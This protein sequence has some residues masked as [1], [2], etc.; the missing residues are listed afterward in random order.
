MS[1]WRLVPDTISLQPCT[2]RAFGR[3]LCP[4]V[5]APGA[6]TFPLGCVPSDPPASRGPCIPSVA[7][8]ALCLL[9]STADISTEAETILSDL[10]SLAETGDQAQSTLQSLRATVRNTGCP[11]VR[12]DAHRPIAP[13]KREEPER[14]VHMTAQSELD[15]QCSRKHSG[16]APLSAGV[17]G[18]SLL[19]TSPRY[20]KRD[21]LADW[22]G[23]TLADAGPEMP[24]AT[25]NLGSIAASDTA[26]SPKQPR[27]DRPPTSRR[28]TRILEVCATTAKTNRTKSTTPHL[29]QCSTHSKPQVPRRHRSLSR[30]AYA[31]DLGSCLPSKVQH[32]SRMLAKMH[33]TARSLSLDSQCLATRGSHFA[34]MHSVT[35]AM[36]LDLH[37]GAASEVAATRPCT[38]SFVLNDLLNV[39]SNTVLQSQKRGSLPQIQSAR[40]VADPAWRSSLDMS[41]WPRRSRLRSVY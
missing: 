20:T 5:P 18:T 30:R 2:R 39:A 17:Y 24:G 23:H 34:K 7:H 33:N 8:F 37:S 6:D 25:A 12:K 32:Q 9:R 22:T 10:R 16:A 28:S 3:R 21:L 40:E 26:I 11:Q 36:V 19:A 14:G 29:A 41:L 35:S 31:E 1:T 38:T 13:A 27:G 4:S 15:L